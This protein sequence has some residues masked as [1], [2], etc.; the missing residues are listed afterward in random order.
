MYGKDTLRQR[1][2]RND[3]GL[4]VVLWTLWGWMGACAKHQAA[5]GGG[6][7]LAGGAGYH[8]WYGHMYGNFR[9]GPQSIC[10]CDEV[11]RVCWV[12]WV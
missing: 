4:S 12:C 1:A 2:R 7:M 10:E 8:Y 9:P 6:G 5:P 11:C 3:K